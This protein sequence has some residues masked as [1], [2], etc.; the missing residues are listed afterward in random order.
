M[1]TIRQIL[2][3][4]FKYDV[5]PEDRLFRAMIMERKRP[6]RDFESLEDFVGGIIDAVKGMC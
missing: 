4:D 2:L 3:T 6:L 1:G 5:K